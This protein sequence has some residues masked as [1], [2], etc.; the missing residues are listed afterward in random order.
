M[1]CLGVFVFELI[2]P[3]TLC[4]C[5]SDESV[6]K[7]IKSSAKADD[8]NVCAKGKSI[9]LL[10]ISTKGTMNGIV[11]VH[12]CTQSSQTSFI[13]SF[14]ERVVGKT[15]YALP[16]RIKNLFFELNTGH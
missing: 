11:T 16:V 1:A 14:A 12:H 7:Y 3:D 2:L 6:R 13:F 15:K 8:H 4:G 10:D 5:N 9:K